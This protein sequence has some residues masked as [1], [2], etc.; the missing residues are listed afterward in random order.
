VPTLRVK[1][2]IAKQVVR[3]A[4]DNESKGKLFFETFFPAQPAES[5]V[6]PN[7]EYPPPKWEFQNITDEQI[8]RSIRKMKPYKATCSSTIPNCVFTHAR[9]LLVP[10]LGPLYRATHNLKHYPDNWAL[11]EILVLKK[12]GRPDYSV[13]SAW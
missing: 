8:H 1:D 3:E 6:P 11:T 12:P 7:P 10:H 13:P 9:E 2:P 5:S 4:V